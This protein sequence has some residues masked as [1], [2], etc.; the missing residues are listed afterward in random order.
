MAMVYA[1]ITLAA[2]S[3][4]DDGNS[5]GTS[6]GSGVV[7]ESAAT[8]TTTEDKAAD[9]A[10]PPTATAKV[11]APSEPASVWLNAFSD[12]Q[13]TSNWT[14]RDGALGLSAYSGNGECSAAFPGATGTYQ[15]KL[16]IQTEY[17]G[18]S[19]YNLS[20]DG[21]VIASGSYPSAS[22]LGCSCPHETWSEDCPDR[23]FDI[24]AG[25]HVIRN[26]AIIRFRGSEDF[27]CG[28]DHGSYAKWHGIQFNPQ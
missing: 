3:S 7:T 11:K 18:Q 28:Q 5:G 10:A 16:S 12:F 2:C 6:G 15:V 4:G 22:P 27:P 14:N 1:I 19:D 24:N 9:S 8:P 21:N 17:D 26:G 13:C 25:T 23:D 20:I